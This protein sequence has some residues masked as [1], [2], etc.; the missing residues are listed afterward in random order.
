MSGYTFIRGRER[1][2]ASG[3]EQRTE[4][5]ASQ[6]RVERKLVCNKYNQVYRAGR[7]RNTSKDNQLIDRKL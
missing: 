3:N 6:Q 2:T 5:A 7:E 4:Y 1:R